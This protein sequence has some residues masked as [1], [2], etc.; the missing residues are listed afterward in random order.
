MIAYNYMIIGSRL[1]AEMQVY[2]ELQI[3][4]VLFS[5]LHMIIVKQVQGRP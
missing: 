3:I 1:L 2:H 5:Q 4:Y